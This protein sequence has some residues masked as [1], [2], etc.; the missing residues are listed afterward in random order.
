MTELITADAETIRKS[1]EALWDV[2]WR[3]ALTRKEAE[4]DTVWVPPKV[5]RPS[6]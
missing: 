4:P 6:R 3:S 2:I 1:S 5:K